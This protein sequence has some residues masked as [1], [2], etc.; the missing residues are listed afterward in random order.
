MQQ[1]ITATGTVQ[2]AQ[3]LT[4]QQLQQLQLKPESLLQQLQNT[5]QRERLRIRQHFMQWDANPS[6]TAKN[7][8]AESPVDKN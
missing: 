5:L 3:Q 6:H 7:A 8:V 1:H 2:T 4:P